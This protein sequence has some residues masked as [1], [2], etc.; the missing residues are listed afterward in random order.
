M[1]SAVMMAKTLLD[2]FGAFDEHLRVGAAYDYW[3]RCLAGGATIGFSDAV[4]LEHRQHDRQMTA[5][6]RM[7]ELQLA[8]DAMIETYLALVEAWNRA[9]TRT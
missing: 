2:R 4:L 9:L 5:P 8:V 3:I 1:P 7:V 6:R